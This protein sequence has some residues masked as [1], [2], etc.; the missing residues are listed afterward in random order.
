MVPL[1]IFNHI[2]STLQQLPVRPVVLVCGEEQQQQPFEKVDGRVTPTQGILHV[3]LVYSIC[4][5]YNFTEQHRCVDPRYKE[6][7]NLGRYFRPTR[8]TLNRLQRKRVLSDTNPPSEH[9][10]KT[11]LKEHPEKVILT[12]T[13]SSSLVNRLP[14]G[15]LAE[16]ADLLGQILYDNDELPVKLYK[17]M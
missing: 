2:T 1:Q 14:V 4:K 11:V 16:T 8:S 6:F 9:R 3:R 17:G 7:L 13:R 5:V 12:V 15:C 10:L